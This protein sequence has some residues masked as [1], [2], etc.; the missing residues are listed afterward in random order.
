MKAPQIMLK[1]PVA[2]LVALALAT[3]CASTGFVDKPAAREGIAAAEPVL[4][5]LANY[6]SANGNFPM[7]FADLSLP[8]SVMSRINEVGLRYLPLR[9]QDSYV[10][11]FNFPVGMGLMNVHCVQSGSSN[12]GRWQCLGK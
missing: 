9:E 2:M 4:V 3:G 11:A 7:S 6:Q 1:Q 12:S 10:V 5:A 8:T